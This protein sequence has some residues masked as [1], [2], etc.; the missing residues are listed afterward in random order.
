MYEGNILF[1]YDTRAVANWSARWLAEWPLRVLERHG[2]V[3]DSMSLFDV[4]HPTI[5]QRR[6]IEGADTI[7]YERHVDGPWMPWFETIC[8]D[9]QFFLLVDDAYWLA[10]PSTPTYQFWSRA[11]RIDLLIEVAEMSTAVVAPCKKLAEY[12]PNGH[13]KPNRPDYSD[14]AWV[15]GRLFSD[16]IV[17]WGGTMGHIEGMTDHPFFGA[18]RRLMQESRAEIVMYAGSPDL[19]ELCKE[20]LPSA[21]VRGDTNSYGEWLQLLSGSQIVACPLGSGYDEYRSW[22]KALEATAAGT[23]WVGDDFGVYDGVKGGVIIP[24]E[25]RTEYDWYWTLRYLLEHRDKRTEIAEEGKRW[26]WCQGLDDHLDE[27]EALFAL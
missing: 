17:F 5:R 10:H 2:Y 19:M 13:Y 7:F 4:L 21:I 22:I 23:V 14:P 3:V 20:E 26:A 12:F 18:G 11:G 25:H 16:N 6:A 27:W 9:K 1:C 8:K 15:I 24:Q